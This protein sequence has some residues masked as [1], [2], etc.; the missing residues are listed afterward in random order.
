MKTAESG[1]QS[2][3][4]KGAVSCSGSGDKLKPKRLDKVFAS[5]AVVKSG[6]KQNE[7]SSAHDRSSVYELGIKS[8][9]N[10]DLI[11]K[12]AR[13]RFESTESEQDVCKK[14]KEEDDP[15]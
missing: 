7:G 4:V 8:K 9:S 10:I 12:L 15:D 14:D 13:S 6:G 1:S 5:G 3:K 2:K 11:D